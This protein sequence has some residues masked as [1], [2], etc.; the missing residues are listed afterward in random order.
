MRRFLIISGRVSAIIVA[1]G[2]TLGPYLDSLPSICLFRTVTGRRCVFCGMSH[3]VT[4]A[5]RGD[6]A[7]A[8][9]AHP[10]WFIILPLFVVF[11]AASI[12]KRARISWGVVGVLVLGTLWTAL[13]P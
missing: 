1:A 2:I 4:L 7:R 10:A 6:F 9:A 8:G 3:A 13:I 12:A 5:V 11:L